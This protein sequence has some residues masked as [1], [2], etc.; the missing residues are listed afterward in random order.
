VK[1]L[2]NGEAWLA[3]VENVDGKIR[4]LSPHRGHSFDI[5]NGHDALVDVSAAFGTSGHDV[6]RELR[7]YAQVAGLR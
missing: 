7:A 5:S 6:E 3:G 2:P 1:V 4:H